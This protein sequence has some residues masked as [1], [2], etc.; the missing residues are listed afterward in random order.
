M[1]V[2]GGPVPNIQSL[3]NIRP[4]AYCRLKELDPAA[5]QWLPPLRSFVTWTPPLDEADRLRRPPGVSDSVF[6]LAAQPVQPMLSWRVFERWVPASYP[7]KADVLHCLRYGV[8]NIMTDQPPELPTVFPNSHKIFL[9]LRST[10]VEIKR[11]EL[12]GRY[13]RVPP[14]VELL[15][16]NKLTVAPKFARPD[17]KREYRA[18]LAKHDVALRGESS[19][20]F[21]LLAGRGVVEELSTPLFAAVPTV[22]HRVCVDATGWRGGRAIGPNSYGEP[23]YAPT[24]SFYRFLWHTTR[25]SVIVVRDIVKAYRTMMIAAGERTYSGLALDGVRYVDLSPSF[26][27]AMSAYNLMT[28]VVMPVQA[29]AIERG[30]TAHG[31]L[32]TNVDDTCASAPPQHAAAQAAAIDSAFADLGV[33]LDPAKAQQSVRVR[34]D[35][36]DVDTEAQTVTVPPEKIESVLFQLDELLAGRET[37][38]VELQSLAGLLVWARNA[39]SQLNPI[40]QAVLALLRE[41]D[42]AASTVLTQDIRAELAFFRRRIPLWSATGFFPVTPAFALGLVSSDAATGLGLGLNIHGQVVAMCPYADEGHINKEEAFAGVAAALIAVSLHRGAERPLHIAIAN[43]NS[44]AVAWLNAGR[45][46]IAHVQQW[47]RIAQRTLA[48]AAVQVSFHWIPSA[49]NTLADAASRHDEG[50]Y[51]A[52]YDGYAA[53][54]GVSAASASPSNAPASYVA[55]ADPSAESLQRLLQRLR[56]CSPDELVYTADAAHELLDELSTAWTDT[57]RAATQRCERT[58]PILH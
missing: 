25:G 45:C 36:L 30:A 49:Y 34:L 7:Y 55:L 3:L 4:L 32:R 58:T 14:Q 11:E 8:R 6:W 1:L 16:I 51:W 21:A 48:V 52:A 26:G 38:R 13:L 19:R 23:P 15:A 46:H 39:A 22:K 37:T 40:L 17:Q 18:R 12:A 10:R 44:S 27:S 9:D 5:P 47:L 50:A 31:P 54:C 28:V 20:D 24:P 29:L 57:H 43:D 2:I 56:D 42:G 41:M 35:G 53:I 33:P